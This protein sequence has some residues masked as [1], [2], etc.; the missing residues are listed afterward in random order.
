MLIG[1]LALLFLV[2]PLF[3]VFQ[4]I[5]EKVFSEKS[6]YNSTEEAVQTEPDKLKKGYDL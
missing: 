5:Q 1:T 4:N 3:M 2:P 6:A